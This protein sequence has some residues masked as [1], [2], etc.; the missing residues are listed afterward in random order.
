MTKEL[1]S[2]KG[3]RATYWWNR[4][5]RDSSKL[6]DKQRLSLVKAILADHCL[7][8]Q[9]ELSLFLDPNFSPSSEDINKTLIYAEAEKKIGDFYSAS[10]PEERTPEYE[11]LERHH[12]EFVTDFGKILEKFYTN[13][14]VSEIFACGM[15]WEDDL[16]TRRLVNSDYFAYRRIRN[17][18]LPR[19]S[20][21]L[22]G[23]VDGNGK[24]VE[25]YDSTHLLFDGPNDAVSQ[26]EKVLC[27]K[28]KDKQ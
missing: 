28:P 6:N 19:I 12:K 22:T 11:N 15:I 21:F 20:T 7:L 4:L 18:Y 3:N 26:I 14:E 25:L 27:I 5:E 16:I 23:S 8:T 9:K 2:E 10:F 13:T 1:S 24:I 17:A